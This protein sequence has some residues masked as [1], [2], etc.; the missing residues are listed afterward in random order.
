MEGLPWRAGGKDRE[1][2]DGKIRSAESGTSGP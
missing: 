1:F 2:L